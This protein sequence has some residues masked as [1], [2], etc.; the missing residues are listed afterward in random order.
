MNELRHYGVKGMKWGVRKERETSNAR[1][2][3]KSLDKSYENTHNDD[4]K[5][6]RDKLKKAIKIGTIAAATALTAYGAFRL[7]D[8]GELSRLISK[9]KAVLDTLERSK[10]TYPSSRITNV[11]TALEK[12]KNPFIKYDATSG[13]MT[14]DEIHSK[15]VAIINPERHRNNCLRCTFAYELNRRGYL[16]KPTKT[17]KGTGQNVARQYNATHKSKPTGIIKGLIKASKDDKD[18]IDWYNF[19]VGYGGTKIDLSGSFPERNIF[20][21][22]ASQPNGARGNLN[23]K[24]NSM[25]GH[26]V[27]WEIIGGKPVIFDCQ[28]NEVF[29]NAKEFSKISD[30][31]LKEVSFQ[32]LDNADLDYDFLLRWCKNVF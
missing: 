21:S 15:V 27:A 30:V 13:P 23:I 31:G 32:R 26:S 19:I 14:I 24:W 8:S 7:V 11:K 9:G 1:R 10:Y 29:K 25:V 2:G 16:V 20:K 5:K 6:R 12:S 18:G 17:L 22:L 3:K 28:T 4:K